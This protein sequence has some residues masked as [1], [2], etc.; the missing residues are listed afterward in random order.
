MIFCSTYYI[1]SNSSFC[2]YNFIYLYS[3][4]KKQL[5]CHPTVQNTGSLITISQADASSA[6]RSSHLMKAASP[7]SA[8]LMLPVLAVLLPQAN[9]RRKKSLPIGKR[10]FIAR[11]YIAAQSLRQTLRGHIRRHHSAAFLQTKELK[12]LL[13]YSPHR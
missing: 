5:I 2:Q 4:Y 7:A 11:L 6:R 1:N 9:N 8:N 3:L 10:F 13:R 12:R